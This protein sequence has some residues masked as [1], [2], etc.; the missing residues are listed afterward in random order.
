MEVTEYLPMRRSFA[1]AIHSSPSGPLRFW[2][3][4]CVAASAAEKIAH[5]PRISVRKQ[6]PG[7][8][9]GRARSCGQRGIMGNA[10]SL[11]RDLELLVLQLAETFGLAPLSGAPRTEAKKRGQMMLSRPRCDSRDGGTSEVCYGAPR[12]SRNFRRAAT[13]PKIHHRKQ[14]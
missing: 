13:R 2:R 12:P 6:F 4:H 8:G 7:A 3:M 14:R 1:Q 9:Q 11:V 5:E 10:S